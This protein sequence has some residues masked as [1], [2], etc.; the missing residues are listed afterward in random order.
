MPL[1]RIPERITMMPDN[2]D[3]PLYTQ[4][5]KHVDDTVLGTLGLVLLLVLATVLVHLAGASAAVAHA[6][7]QGREA[8]ALHCARN[9]VDFTD[10]NIVSCYTSRGVPVPGDL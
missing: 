9:L 6:R 4:R 7:T 2:I 5:A 3:Y 10:A 8:A 1:N